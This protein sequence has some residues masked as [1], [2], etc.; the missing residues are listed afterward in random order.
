[1]G[2]GEHGV[3]M[4]PQYQSSACVWQSTAQELVAAGYRVLLLEYRCTQVSDCPTD[5][6]AATQLQLDVAAGVKELHAEGAKKVVIVGASAGGTLAIVA[7]AAAGPLV[8][9]VIDLSGPAD[10]SNLYGAPNERLDS[11]TAA[12]KLVV[13]ALMVLAQEDPSTSEVEFRN[14]Y[15]K[16]PGPHKKL[17]ILPADAGHGWSMLGYSGPEGNVTDEIN[18]FLK[19]ND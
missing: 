12:P 13:P 17:L 19:A 6:D 8:N 18:A 15:N 2:T 14:V 3:L 10:V 16:L 1:M 4:L 5:A 7:G 9:G 11:F